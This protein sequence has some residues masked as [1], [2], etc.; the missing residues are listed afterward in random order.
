MSNKTIFWDWNGTLLNDVDA[1]VKAMNK[2]L[3]NRKMKA[4]TADY[5]K[6]IFGFP[7][8]DYYKKLGFKFETETFEEVSV[9]FINEYNNQV[10]DSSLHENALEA[11]EH[12]KAKKYNQVVISAMEHTM[13][14]EMLENYNIRKYFTE[15]KGLKD[16]YAK[17][18]LHLAEEY[19]NE[20]DLEPQDIL[21]IGDTLH[22]AEVADDI[23]SKLVLVA[24]G[25]YSKERLSVNGYEVVDNLIQLSLSKY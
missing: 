8:K 17:G 13:L 1:C 11:L 14:E 16:I 5:Y 12:F 22:D 21:F 19:I 15:V 25:H 3:S 18:K 23:S 9:E 20:K 2:L 7:V 24:N 10:T 4:I 6:S